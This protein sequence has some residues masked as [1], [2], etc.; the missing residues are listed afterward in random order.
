M[1]ICPNCQ[2][3]NVADNAFCEKCGQDLSQVAEKKATTTAPREPKAE[4]TTE[5]TTAA[6]TKICPNCQHVNGAENA[7]C[8]QCGQ[9]L[10]QVKAQAATTGKRRQAKYGERT[11][12]AKPWVKRSVWGVIGLVVVIVVVLG[13]SFYQKQV[14]KSKQIATMTDLVKTN[15]SAQ[16]A[17]QLVSDDPSLKITGKTVQ[18]FMAY[19]RQHSDYVT[20]M[21]TDLDQNGATSDHIFTLKTVGHNWLIF[22][23]YK[24]QVK[25]M[26]PA[27]TTNI[28]NAD[29][30][31]NGTVLTTTKNAHYVYNAGPLFPGHYTF[32]LVGT[33]S[34]ATQT[35]DLMRTNAVNQSISLLAKAAKAGQDT[36]S[37]SASTGAASDKP[38]GDDTTHTGQAYEDLSS[39]AQEAV[40]SIADKTALDSDDYTYTESEPNT[41]VYEIKLY[42]KDTDDYVSTYRYDTVNHIL[43]ELN[44]GTGKF[45]E[46]D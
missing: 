7:F 25:T 39:S 22:P 9:D 8:E 36:A 45:D 31:A 4:P 34:S 46:V 3:E 10:S 40:A 30:Q 13:I 12:K 21:K 17:K 19:V 28:S 27:I 14:G 1:K 43:A 35:V 23:V 33:Q 11:G 38:T 5:P 15:Q 32:K 6:T 26:H 24:L 29:I 20:N 41:D 37:D 16:F 44:T 18:P 2:H 42:D